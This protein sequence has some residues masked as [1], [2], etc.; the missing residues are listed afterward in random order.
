[1]GVNNYLANFT[2]NQVSGYLGKS[3]EYDFNKTIDRVIKSHGW[4]KTDKLAVINDD[5]FLHWLP[6]LRK[7]VNEEEPKG[8]DDDGF[9]PQGRAEQR[10]AEEFGGDDDYLVQEAFDTFELTKGKD[11][12]ANDVID[13]PPRI[14]SPVKIASPVRA[15]SSS[16]TKQQCACK[17]LKG[18][19]CSRNAAVG[20]F[21]KQH[22]SCNRPY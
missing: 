8:F 21:C 13:T 20:R 3:D 11:P 1:M 2:T 14:P 18:T 19:R 15:T 10:Y 5:G 22:A 9:G 12:A 17:T 16:A 4:K 7:L 6:D